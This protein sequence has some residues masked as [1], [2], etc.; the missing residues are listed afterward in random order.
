MAEAICKHENSP[1]VRQGN[2]VLRR[3]FRIRGGCEHAACR[4][5]QDGPLA[6][7]LYACKFS[8]FAAA[9]DLLAVASMV[10]G[11]TVS[12]AGRP[13]QLLGQV[14]Y[15]AAPNQCI[16]LGATRS[17]IILIIEQHAGLGI[18][19]L[20]RRRAPPRCLRGYRV[21]RAVTPSVP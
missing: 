2:R 18:G 16:I 20:I 14:S 4:H 1:H 7:R 19:S 13:G 3:A 10:L 8:V 11:C 15:T 6:P 21:R 12:Q 5:K 9:V 17:T